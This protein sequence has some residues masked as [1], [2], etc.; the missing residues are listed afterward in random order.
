MTRKA[1]GSTICIGTSPAMMFYGLSLAVQG[2]RIAFIDRA[3]D[4]G[5]AWRTRYLFGCSGVELGVHLVENRRASNRALA[6]LIGEHNL[7]YGPFGFGLIGQKRISLLASRILLHSGLTTK[8]ASR[9][10]AEAV[11]HA[12][13]TGSSLLELQTPFA[14]PFGGFSTVLRELRDR[15]LTLGASFMLG[16]EA[17]EI[18]LTGTGAL[19]RECEETHS[20]DRVVISSRAHTTVAGMQ[21]WMGDIRKTT[22]SNFAFVVPHECLKFRGYVEI[23]S[24]PVVKRVR[25]LSSLGLHS[26]HGEILVAQ[27]RASTDIDDGSGVLA[28][29][30]NEARRLRLI[31][32]AATALMFH[33]EIFRVSTLSARAIKKIETHAGGRILCLRTIDF[34]D[35]PR[36]YLANIGKIALWL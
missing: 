32:E 3:Q 8:A 1:K 33:R 11:S 18:E 19:V 25:E 9:M 31:R 13:R 4:V 27:S 7:I 16:R 5:G 36:S 28:E 30:L 26:P 24:N 10:D 12:S 34:S 17:V 35:Q 15:L 22:I 21:K 29:L 6:E 23:F 20:C 2:E 14:Y